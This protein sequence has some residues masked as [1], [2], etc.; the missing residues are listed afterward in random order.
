MQNPIARCDVDRPLEH[1]AQ[2]SHQTRRGFLMNTVAVL[3]L[4]S[5]SIAAP[6]LVQPDAKMLELG[7]QLEVAWAEENAV[8]LKTD[9]MDDFVEADR[10]CG[11]AADRTSAIV[12]QI[13]RLSAS[14]IDGL[15]VKAKAVM[16]CRS[17]DPFDNHEDPQTADARLCYSIFQDLT[18]IGGLRAA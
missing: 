6:S 13:E 1:F 9:L 12:A 15:L 17:G 5:P 3:P 2:V 14:T 8:N 4:S 10:L 18:A 7:A 11:E 16:W